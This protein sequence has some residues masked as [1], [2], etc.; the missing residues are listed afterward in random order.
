MPALLGVPPGARA[1]TVFQLDARVVFFTMV[2]TMV[3]TCLFGIV[4]SWLASRGDVAPVMKEGTAA[5]GPR[6]HRGLQQG[7]V[8]SQIAVSVVLLCGAA[9]MTRSFLQTERAGL[10]VTRQPVLSAWVSGED[11]TRAGVEDAMARLAATPGVERVAIAFRAPLS[12]SGGGMARP[13]YFPDAPPA[14]GEGLPD[15][16]F[17]PVSASYF[18]TMGTRVLRGRVLT[19]ADEGAG[20][21]VMVVNEEFERRFFPGGTAVDRR[22]QPGGPTAPVHRIV[23]VVENAVINSIGEEPEPYFYLPFWRRG[24]GEVTFLVR[25]TSDASAFAPIVK[26]ILESVDPRLRPRRIV[27]MRE[28]MAYSASDYRATAALALTLGLVGLLLTVLGVYG[29]IAYR[30]AQ[31]TREIG[32]R[33]ALGAA[34]GDVLRMMLIEGGRV[35]VAGVGIGLMLALAATRA[36]QSMLFHVSAWDPASFT[37]SAVVVFALA[38]VA[39]AIPAW[40]AV[41]S[42][43]AAALRL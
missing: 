8:V 19:R 41:R 28:Y 23:G 33:M 31:R 12:L 38:C 3:T 21:P 16:K 14:P 11:F 10:G 24:S 25:T 26:D 37:T 30:T 13:V 43:P 42:S 40:R 9:V 32:I 18:D 20:E 5:S 15:V 7:L 29:V 34:R 35:A 17:N 39:I 22:V 27:T 4:P 1:F 6:V 36:I 2:V